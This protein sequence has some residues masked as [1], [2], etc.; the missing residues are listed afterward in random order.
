MLFGQP[1]LKKK[2]KYEL[3]HVCQMKTD[4]LQILIMNIEALSTP[5]GVDFARSFIFSLVRVSWSLMSQP[6]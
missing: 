4:E 1:H 6:R 2:N 3:E 5:R